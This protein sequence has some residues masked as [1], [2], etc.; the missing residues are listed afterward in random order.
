MTASPKIV[1]AGCDYVA[2]E[3]SQLTLKEGDRIIVLSEDDDRYWKGRL[4]NG[5]EGFFPIHAIKV[6][7]EIY[8]VGEGV[9]ERPLPY[10]W[11]REMDDDGQLLYMNTITKE[12]QTEFPTQRARPKPRGHR[13]KQSTTNEGGANKKTATE[14]YREQRARE[15][16]KAN[17][18]TPRFGGTGTAKPLVNSCADACVVL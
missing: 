13:T 9:D 12:T 8:G 2:K 11:K 7:S 14:L 1:V 6:N 10:G 5:Q 15:G 17:K 3:N 4:E 18:Y 16:P